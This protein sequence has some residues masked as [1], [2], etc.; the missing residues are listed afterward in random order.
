MPLMLTASLFLTVLI[1]DPKLPVR[2]E[3]TIEGWTV[4]I[5]RR[6]SEP[7]NEA[8]GK[9]AIRLLGSQLVQ[10]QVALSPDLI[11]RLRKVPIFLDLACGDMFSPAYH[12]SA[13]W[14]RQN[15]YSEKME[16]SVHIPKAEYF[17]SKPF[18]TQQ[19]WA[20]LHELAHAYHHQDLKY[21]NSEILGLYDKFK[22]NTKYETPS[23]AA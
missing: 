13:V 7:K 10:I 4:H 1:Q 18:Q 3:E 8:L 14:L 11:I 12:P 19:P 16:R 23:A 5:D 22:S 17:V 6:L 9:Q 21:E 15:G 2:R 20:M